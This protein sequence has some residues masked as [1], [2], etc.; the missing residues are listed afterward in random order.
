M[1]TTT[2]VPAT[3]ASTGVGG[4]VAAAVP[5]TFQ[6]I[7]TPV[8]GQSSS[9]S[10][11][12]TTSAW[13]LTPTSSSSTLIKQPS[14]VSIINGNMN[15]TSSTSV[16]INS[17]GVTMPTNGNILYITTT[18]SQ[19][20]NPITTGN[21]ILQSPQT[22]RLLTATPLQTSL[23]T[24]TL[25]LLN[26]NNPRQIL[27]PPNSNFK[28][29]TCID[30][31]ILGRLAPITIQRQITTNSPVQQSQS[32]PATTQ[33][34]NNNNNQN[35]QQINSTNSCI[36]SNDD[37]SLINNSQD[38]E[39]EIF[40]N[41]VVCSFSLC[42]KLDL[43][44]IA[45]EAANVIYKRE[46]AM[47]LMKIRNP[48]CS[49]NIWSSGKVTVTGTTSE[50]DARRGARRIARSLQRLGFKTKFRHYR[51]VNCL[52]TCAMPWPIDIIKLS[53]LYHEC[54][55]YEPEIHPG[56]TVRLPDKAV[57]KVFTTGSVTLTAPSVERINTAV[58][59][60]YP[61]LFECRK[62]KL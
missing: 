28:P 37:N 4:P 5:P 18:N 42:C 36:V 25:T 15:V 10:S 31:P 30:T 61:Q 22:V 40:V 59:E 48:N 24:S 29:G 16:P 26:N 1:F 13:R 41:N 32:L 39:I 57:L 12:T 51:V 56:A 9:S 54:V 52:A 20:Y 38:Q 53:R 44:R 60:F 50:D 7:S 49:A 6:I 58:N 34:Q 43:R 3:A 2:N 21:I 8:T 62:I 17:T 23:S 45:K 35:A 33:N 46:Q 47:V 14:V 11:S 19:Q 27:T 55:S